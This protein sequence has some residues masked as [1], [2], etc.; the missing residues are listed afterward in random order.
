MKTAQRL[1]KWNQQRLAFFLFASVVQ[2]ITQ[3]LVLFIYFSF[4]LIIYLVLQ[5]V[6]RQFVP[7]TT[8]S[9]SDK[10]PMDEWTVEAQVSSDKLCYL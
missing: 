8:Y 1:L 4:Y 9:S 10:D 7:E 3:S 6:N 5:F 2:E